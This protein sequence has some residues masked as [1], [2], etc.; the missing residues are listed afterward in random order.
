LKEA[1]R[2]NTSSIEKIQTPSGFSEATQVTRYWSE[3]FK[4][5]RKKKSL[6]QNFVLCKIIF[7]KWRKI[8]LKIF[9][10]F[11]TSF[12]QKMEDGGTHLNSFYEAIIPPNQ[13]QRL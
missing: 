3:I 7:Q 11:K 1:R 2:E 5:L 9:N 10:H 6:N 13:S 8:H 4:V 12:P